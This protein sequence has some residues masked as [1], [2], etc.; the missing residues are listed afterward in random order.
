MKIS[1]QIESRYYMKKTRLEE[2]ILYAG[3]MGYKNLGIAFGLDKDSY[4]LD[5]VQESK[6][7]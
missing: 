6:K 5:E 2:L 7:L 4:G 3:G 1:A